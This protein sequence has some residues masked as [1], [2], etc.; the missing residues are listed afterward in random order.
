MAS[1]PRDSGVSLTPFFDR[2]KLPS[3]VKDDCDAFVRRRYE[4]RPIR[5]APFQGYCSYTVFIG[6]DIVVQF[7][8]SA[9]KLDIDITATACQIFGTLAPETLYLGDLSATDLCAFEMKRLPGVSLSD[10]RAG[11]TARSFRER[12]VRDFAHLQAQAWHHSKAKSDLRGIERTV[13]SSLRW[14]LESMSVSLPS[15]ASRD[16]AQSILAKL[17]LI[18]DLPWVLSHGDF[19][20][21]NIM[22]CP[23][24][25]KLL[26]LLD[27]A[28]AEWLPFGIG[29]YG[30]EELLGEDENGKFVY[31]PEAEQ[32]R[33][34]F[35]EELLNSLPRLAKDSRAIASAKLA[36][37]L[38][39]L[40]WH[41]IAFDDG[42]L[43]RVVEEG[44]DDQEIQRLELFISHTTDTHTHRL[45]IIQPFLESALATVR[46]LI[47]RKS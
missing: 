37:Q 6:E 10:L 41:G 27:W 12:L 34:L 39:I 9:H 23:K 29:A 4:S 44:K 17:S 16:V 5:P 30:L 15:G 14:R 8:P 7:R 32:L 26:G 47:L 13:G 2:C 40:L 45:R 38:G 18:E 3:S 20:P 25:G 43:N 19:L 35:W 36:Q 46:N 21:S 42:R 24:S 11:S 31:Y 22:V 28:E 33:S 1:S